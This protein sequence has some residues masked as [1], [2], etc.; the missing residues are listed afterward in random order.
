MKLASLSLLLLL[1]MFA[2]AQ[3][4]PRPFISQPLVPAAA[5]PGSGT[6]M[7]H[8]SGTGFVSG[9][10][11]N[12]DGSALATTFVSSSELTAP[13]PAANVASRRTAT[14]TVS[15]PAPG[16]GISNEVPF[17]VRQA[18]PGFGARKFIL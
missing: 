18:T 5:K 3:S 14:I 15:N 7:L 10:V 4:N 11:V 9:A 2:A 6:F 16:G 8:V 17:P 1:A 12:W 13:V